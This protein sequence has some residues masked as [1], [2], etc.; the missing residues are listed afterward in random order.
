[1]SLILLASKTQL[2]APIFWPSLVSAEFPVSISMSVLRLGLLL[3]LLSLAE[4]YAW[5]AKIKAPSLMNLRKMQKG[6]KFGEK[7]L[8]LS[9][10]K[11]LLSLFTCFFH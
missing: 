10:F 9:R 11:M 5:M 1:M 8:L 4:G 6:S 2:L 7:T 3:S